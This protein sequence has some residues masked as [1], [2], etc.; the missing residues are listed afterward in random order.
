VGKS[1]TRRPFARSVVLAAV[2]C[3]L[4]AL[5]APLP[6]LA[7]NVTFE[8]PRLTATMRELN[9]SVSF[10]SSETPVRAELM[11]RIRSQDAWSVQEAT[12]G[13]GSGRY[14][15]T[16]D[17]TR[18]RLPNTPL[19]YRF[20]VTTASGVSLSEE[21]ELTVV[22]ARFK[23]QVLEGRFV[24]L[25]WYRGGQDFGRRAL[26]VGD[27]AIADATKLLG[28]TETE[29]IDFF[30]YSSN[31]AYREALGPG[32]PENSAGQ[33]NPTIRTLFALID[34]AQI[35]STWVPVVITHELTHLVFNTAT[36]NPYHGPP[37]WLNEGLAVY[38]SEGFGAGN[39]VRLA[40]A[41]ARDSIIPLDG[42][43]IQF[44]PGEKFFLSYA[45]SVSAVDFFIRKYGQPTL[46]KLVRS[47]A[48]GVSDD[49]AFKA[50]T[51]AD[52]K[53]FNLA[54]LADLGVKMPD[55][56]GPQ[57]APPGPLPAD[58]TG[59][60]PTPA[61]TSQP[62]PSRVPS[63]LPQVSPAPPAAPND[64][65]A[66]GDGELPLIALGALLL[67]LGLALLGGLAFA[68]RR[69]GTPGTPPPPAS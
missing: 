4:L 13:G 56:T 67:A 30:V 11:T 31:D 43:A 57:P 35:N 69:S 51:G 63:A 36:A 54:W 34:P 3:S 46:V 28:V 66:D 64:L 50:A 9:A 19:V 41:K 53:A 18:R 15:A 58:W 42:L 22:D 55:P 49:D 32:T 68:R 2:I 1:V 33:A 60:A 24:R 59:P 47:Y 40:N 39:R 6:A 26:E 5:V 17:S 37:R 23:W 12:V 8:T 61:A 62:I 10:T 21:Q 38:R 65:P 16:L 7:A 29:P 52:V 44:P 14:T 27:K 48:G 45:E 20:R 25:H